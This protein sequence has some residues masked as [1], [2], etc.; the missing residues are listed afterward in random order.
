[1]ATKPTIANSAWATDAAFSS[2]PANG[3]PTKVDPT[4]TKAQGWRPGDALGFVAAWANY[5]L[6]QFYLW[7]VYVNDLHNSADFLNKS[8]TWLTGIHRFTGGMRSAGI[9]LESGDVLY[10]DAAGAASPRLTV[11]SVPWILSSYNQNGANAQVGWSIAGAGNIYNSLSDGTNYVVM[12]PVD[13]ATLPHGSG[14]DGVR[15][16]AN[17]G[18]GNIVIDIA[19]YPINHTTGAIGSYVQLA[20]GTYTG[21]SL[22]GSALNT[23]GMAHTVDHNAN[24]YF[25]VISSNGAAAG[26]QAIN[27][28]YLQF[29]DLGFKGN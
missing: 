27:D 4:A 11:R 15:A 26:A 3:K 19:Y 25:F 12:I 1:M 18:G 16:W 2:G 5:M 9:G 23:S 17:A 10:T 24:R 14:L 13:N 6:N 29:Y 21:S 8:Y 28:I 22:I 7:C 20:T